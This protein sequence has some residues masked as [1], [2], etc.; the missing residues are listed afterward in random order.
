MFEKFSI[1]LLLWYYCYYYHC[2]SY[3]YAEYEKK[4]EMVCIT[5]YTERE[6]RR[7]HTEFRTTIVAF[8]R[9]TT[10]EEKFTKYWFFSN[11]RQSSYSSYMKITCF[12]FLSRPSIT[13]AFVVVDAAVVA[14]F[15]L[16]VCINVRY[17]NVRTETVHSILTV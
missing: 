15:G 1:D 5:C 16:G 3:Y 8:W 2:H 14:L 4:Y 9:F 12:F 17:L 11:S 10:H 13:V 7:S 6:R